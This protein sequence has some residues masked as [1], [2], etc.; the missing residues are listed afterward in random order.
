VV[1]KVL[2]LYRWAL[3]S[4]RCR[5]VVKADDDTWV[6]LPLLAASLALAPPQGTYYGQF[7]AGAATRV[8]TLHTE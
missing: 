2:H 3:A 5:F 4:T 7:C 8:S 6:R 1:D